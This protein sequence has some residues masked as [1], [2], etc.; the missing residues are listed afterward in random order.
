[1]KINKIKFVRGE[2]EGRGFEWKKRRI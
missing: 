2:G 1:M